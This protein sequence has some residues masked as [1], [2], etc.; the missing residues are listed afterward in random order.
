MTLFIRARQ[1]NSISLRSVIILFTR[2]LPSD[3]QLKCVHFHIFSSY[4]MLCPPH[5]PDL[6]I[7]MYKV[8]VMRFFITYFSTSACYFF[9]VGPKYSPQ[10]YFP[11]HPSILKGLNNLYLNQER[12]ET[13]K[14]LL[15]SMIAM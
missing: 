9:P 7:I 13:Q 15:P 3:F 12:N 8:Q 5:P 14:C 1:I 10:K 6:I 2:F 11:M 4:Y